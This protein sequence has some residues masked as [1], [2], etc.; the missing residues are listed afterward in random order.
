M[1]EDKKPLQN[2]ADAIS[3]CADLLERDAFLLRTLS[4]AIYHETVSEH[5]KVCYSVSA[6]NLVS[7]LQSVL[8]RYN[9]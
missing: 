9:K 6:E 3:R 1:E 4:G 8:E 7:V 5:Q 2:L